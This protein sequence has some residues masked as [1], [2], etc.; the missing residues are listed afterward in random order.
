MNGGR[1]EL[2]EKIAVTIWMLNER[3]VIV[4]ARFNESRLTYKT[5]F[6]NEANPYTWFLGFP[7]GKVTGFQ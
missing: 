3:K 4:I 5:K 6:M 7:R 2:N 1:K